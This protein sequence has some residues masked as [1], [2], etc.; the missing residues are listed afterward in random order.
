MKIISMALALGLVVGCM[1]QRGLDTDQ[2]DLLVFRGTV[3]AIVNSPIQRSNHN[4]M[5]TMR[6][7]QIDRGQFNGPTFNFRVHSPSQSGLISNGT[8]RVETKLTQDGYTVDEFQWN[9]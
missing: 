5:I 3:T 7:D 4:W 2:S 6:V 1:S 8:Y 9:R